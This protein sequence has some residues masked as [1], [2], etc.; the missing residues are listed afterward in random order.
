MTPVALQLESCLHIAPEA[1][2]IRSPGLTRHTAPQLSRYPL[3]SS[4]VPGDHLV[5]Y[6][7][8]AALAHWARVFKLSGIWS[9]TCDLI[10]CTFQML[11]ST[12][13]ICDLMRFKRQPAHMQLLDAQRAANYPCMA[14]SDQGAA[15]WAPASGSRDK[16]RFSQWGKNRSL[17]RK[18]HPVFVCVICCG[19]SKSGESPCACSCACLGLRGNHFTF[20]C[21][22]EC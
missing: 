21:N 1:V 18:V 19:Y 2:H 12:A 22:G 15:L 9:I 14:V 10:A 20:L 7:L 11:P 4:H 6:S 8:F 3:L 5:V 13:C 16:I 17:N